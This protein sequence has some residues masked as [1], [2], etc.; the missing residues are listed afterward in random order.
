VA[1][2]TDSVNTLGLTAS[3]D[4]DAA[5]NWKAGTT[6]YYLY[7]KT[8]GA[9]ASFE[10]KVDANAKVD[11]FTMDQPEIAVNGE[12]TVIPFS[13]VDQYGKEITDFNVLNQ[14][15]SG[16]AFTS[17]G[18]SGPLNIAV[19]FKPD[20]SKD[21]KAK[22]V[23]DATHVASLTNDTTVYINAYTSTGKYTTLSVTLKPEA[24]PV[25]IF[26]VTDVDYAIANAATDKFQRAD[27]SVYDQY[28]RKKA[29]SDFTAYGATVTTSSNTIITV[30]GGTSATMNS[31]HD[32]IAFS[33]I[34][35]NSS[36]ATITMQLIDSSN[37]PIA[38]SEHKF[39]IRNVLQSE[40]A[41]Y[42]VADITKLYADGIMTQSV[43]VKGALADGTAVTLP[44]PGIV[45]TVNKATYNNYY[46]VTD[47]QY[48][49]YT[50]SGTVVTQ[51]T[52][53]FGSDSEK[54]YQIVITTT[55]KDK[56]QKFFTKQVVVSNVA[57]EAATLALQSNG[58]ATK[59]SDAVLSVAASDINNQGATAL[60][61]AGIKVTDQYGKE[62]TSAT[63]FDSIVVSGFSAN[64]I[65]TLVAGDSFS[66]T[67][68]ADSKAVTVKVNVK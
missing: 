22:L 14:Q 23:L 48:V 52:V 12:E 30:D 49:H 21:G 29:L 50:T 11:S 31:G 7:S 5:G 46:S 3:V 9:Q 4:S 20:A 38:D 62:I 24:K 51:G 16:K 53:P 15:G 39:V 18:V 2:Y 26:A 34:S 57:P 27:V 40:I 36:S 33:A 44:T 65:G 25:D 54:T 45:D 1:G 55:N 61:N 68:V 66:F 8:T 67:A 17:F 43:T 59:E 64:A 13:A 19:T 41:D 63:K 58:I 56:V 28:G 60:A 35:A 10:L 37:N 32:E 42:T 6:T 47:A